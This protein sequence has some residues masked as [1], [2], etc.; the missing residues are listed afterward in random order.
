MNA[1]NA[2]DTAWLKP[3]P[4]FTRHVLRTLHADAAQAVLVG[5]SPFDVATAHNAAF[6]CWCVTTGTHTAD[7][8]REA[9]ADAVFASLLELGGAL[10]IPPAGC[11][12]PDE[13]RG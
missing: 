10:G 1:V 4:E 6:P 11:R 9:G 8:L 5:D 12:N 7:Q 3:Q 2:G 13:Y